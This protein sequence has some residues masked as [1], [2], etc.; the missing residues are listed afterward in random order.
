ME[1]YD[2][3]I[4][5]GGPAGLNA[6]LVLGRAKRSVA[7]FDAGTPRNR[8]AHASHGYL[9]RD[10]IEPAEFRRIAYEEVLR[11]PSVVRR[12]TEVVEVRRSAEGFT[13]TTSDG[14]TVGARKLIIAVGLKEEPQQIEGLADF[15]G[16]TAFNCPFCDGWELRDRPLAVISSD[17]YAFHKTKL[18]Y[19][20]T[21]DLV[22]CT[23]G[24]NPLSEEERSQ[25]ISRGI[26]IEEAPV[27]AMEGRDG[28]LEKIRFGD[29]TSIDRE[30]A[31]VSPKLLANRLF[32][33]ELGYRIADNG[34]VETDAM[35]KTSVPGVFAAGDSAYFMPSQL[36]LAAASGSKAAASVMAELTDED[37]QRA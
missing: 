29:G 36:I 32:E 31:L 22:L 34:S 4:V 15:Y 26:R 20:W 27:T 24:G 2:C 19:N 37:W 16:Q 17:S 7:L 12:Q 35:G 30:G 11:Y 1:N 25:L 13:L 5:G 21:K 14:G 23:D 3:A 6:A 18:L 28:R 10:G 9:T 33:Q 8:V